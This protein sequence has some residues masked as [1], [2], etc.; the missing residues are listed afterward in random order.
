MNGAREY[1]SLFQTGQ[2]GR[3]YFE[4]G[5]H[6]RGKTFHIYVLPGDVE[7]TDTRQFNNIRNSQVVEVYGVTG[8]QPGWTESYGWLYVGPWQ[9]EFQKLVIATNVAIQE[10][11]IKREQIV[12]D[13][14]NEEEQRVKQLLNNYIKETTL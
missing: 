11:A 7:I 8:G 12:Q 13:K 1:A 9:Q 10:A 4:V 14:I 2:Y 5:S 6:A 3:L